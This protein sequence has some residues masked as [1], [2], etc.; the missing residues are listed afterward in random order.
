MRE[1]FHRMR[2]AAEASNFTSFLNQI[3]NSS[4]VRDN[5]HF[6]SLLLEAA[7][8]ARKALGIGRDEAGT[9]VL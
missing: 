7:D 2:K 8:D 4:E 9:V 5:P 3:K 6:R 1:T